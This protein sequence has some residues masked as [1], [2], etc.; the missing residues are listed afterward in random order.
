MET[1]G[2]PFSIKQVRAVPK[3]PS[4]GL[5]AGQKGVEIPEG[6]LQPMKGTKGNAHRLKKG[7]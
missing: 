5:Y 4:H 7:L 1:G 3:W 2:N 6:K